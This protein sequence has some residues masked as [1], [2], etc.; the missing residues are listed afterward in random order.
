[1]S[2]TLFPNRRDFLRTGA[3]LAGS[4][5]A[6]PTLIPRGAL[7]AEGRPGANDRI[8]IGYIGAGRRAQQLMDIPKEGQT[9]AVCDIS[10][11]R[12][13]KIGNKLSCAFFQDYHR[14]LEQKAVDAVI[15]AT[16]D[17][18]HALHTIHACQAGKDVYCEKPLSLTIR[19]GRAMVA[20]ARKYKRIVQTGS[21][22]RSMA[23]NRRGCEM[24]RNGVIGKVHTIITSNLPSPWEARLPGQPIPDGLDWDAWCG[25]TVAAPFNNDIF[26]S[27]SNPGW[28]SLRPYSG[29][30]M[31]GWGAHSLDQ[32]QCALGMDKSGPVE[33]WVEGEKFAPPTYTEPGK[34][35]D[36]NAQCTHP[37]VFFRYADGPVVK[38]ERIFCTGRYGRNPKPNEG[39]DAGAIFVGEK[40]KITI[41]R[42][43][44]NVEPA[45]L[46]NEP[47][48][49]VKLDECVEHMQN[50]FDCI[51]SRQL[52]VADV[53]IG[54]RS[55]SICHLG[56]IGRWVGRKLTWDPVLETFPGD[57]EANRCLS[58]PMR[59]GYQLP[60]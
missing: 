28:I 23:P 10:L 17:H 6:L 54:H 52:P 33:V 41:D 4:C 7:A 24:I 40:G 46:G 14:L 47:P 35:D 44:C 29:G 21:Q 49:S 8:G 42:D 43:F 12:A 1:M 55:T 15:V 37:K 34:I 13:E 45:E 5:I 51:R 20:A 22:Q 26:I 48:G 38:M 9:V 56:N 59:E 53:E 32:I 36:G 16:P 57:D 2:Q 27:R 30:E 19:E 18:W 58:R 60:E 25:Q 11:S 39:P 50:W 3:A 31:T